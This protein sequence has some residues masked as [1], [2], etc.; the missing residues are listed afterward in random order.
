MGWIFVEKDANGGMRRELPIQA[1]K[2]QTFSITKTAGS[3]MPLPNDKNGAMTLGVLT[4][5][6]WGAKLEARNE[7]LTINPGAH[8]EDDIADPSE[9]FVLQPS[10]KERSEVILLRNNDVIHSSRLPNAHIALVWKAPEVQ[11]NSSETPNAEI[12]DSE[13]A[14]A[15]DGPEQETEDDEDL[16]RTVVI[17]SNDSRATPLL[18]APRTEV[19][20]ETPTIDRINLDVP[21]GEAFSTAPTKMDE[22]RDAK[23]V[24]AEEAPDANV[25]EDSPV[26]SEPVTSR[27][28]SP[29][30]RIDNSS[31]KKRASPS[32]V[33]DEDE[34]D[35]IPAARP[36][37]RR[38]AGDVAAVTAD[39]TS[40]QATTRKPAAKGRKRL[41]DTPQESTPSRSQRGSQKGSQTSFQGDYEGPP[42]RVA[43]SL[44]SIKS[45]SNFVRFLKKNDGAFLEKVDDTCNVLC[46]KDDTPLVKTMK[47]LQSIALG[48]PIVTDQWLI[49]SSLAGRLLPLK[50][51]MPS[52][53]AQE[54]EWKF[55]LAS[56]WSTPQNTLFEG[57]TILFTPALKAT[58]ADF[59]EVEQVCK[60]VGA[61]KVVCKRPTAKD[62]ES[63]E[64]ILLA[65][66]EGDAE[67]VGGTC[68]SKDFLT[69]SILRG[70]AIDLE[71]E[72]FQFVAKP[73]VA[74]GVGAGAGAKG[75]EAP[76]KKGR[77]KKT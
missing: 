77:P 52:V 45:T 36:A 9:A 60:A 41:S 46:V 29:L 67:A 39:K 4:F 16:D 37:K 43:F 2:G 66:D 68:F 30:V 38:K 44:S 17:A 12:P 56:V 54:K 57:Y 31:R 64:T 75:A 18:S 34:E 28:R 5:E 15:P 11:V 8:Y 23:E 51:Y 13:D 59:K 21:L 35:E 42:P 65:A 27:R 32:D 71:S 53:P 61:K 76:K 19:I 69:M 70:G 74:V 63:A 48:I 22:M 73:G 40:A 55:S 14:T 20:Q 10:S 72:E 1:Q 3:W 7:P 25:K 6:T 62:V 33:D 26:P 49:D 58:Y 50:P 24:A 47:L